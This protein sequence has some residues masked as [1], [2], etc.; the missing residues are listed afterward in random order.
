MN[1]RLPIKPEVGQLWADNDPRAKGRT[2]LIISIGTVRALA[3]VVTNRETAKQSTV[4][5][6]VSILREQLRPTKNGYR[7]MEER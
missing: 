7:L 1:K 6:Y 5:L 3:R 2:V 4:G